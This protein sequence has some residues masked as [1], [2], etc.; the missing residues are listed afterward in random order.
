MK[1]FFVWKKRAGD[2]VESGPQKVRLGQGTW[3]LPSEPGVVGEE[4]V[5]LWEGVC[6]D[7]RRYCTGLDLRRFVNGS[8]ISQNIVQN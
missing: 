8:L 4:V 7:P 3:H 2:S 1:H 5:F 6:G